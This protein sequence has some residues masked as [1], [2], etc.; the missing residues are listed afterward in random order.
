L[1]KKIFF[2]NLENLKSLD[3]YKVLLQSLYKKESALL[4]K[5]KDHI[6]CRPGCSECCILESLFPVEA[7]LVFKE[8]QTKKIRP[9]YPLKP[10]VCP[11][12]KD[13]K[14]LVYD[15]RPVICRTHG[16]PVIIDGLIDYCP[17]NFKGLESIP[18][19]FFLD[20]NNVNQALAGINALFLKEQQALAPDNRAFYSHRI[21]ISKILESVNFS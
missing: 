1:K 17:K 20:I 11:L 18:L 15:V 16:H 8:I 21:K 19:N 4:S 14:C 9:E 2:K 12:L 10:G 7:A 13:N 3:H 6:Y 5:Y